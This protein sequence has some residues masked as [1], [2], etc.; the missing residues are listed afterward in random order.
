[1]GFEAIFQNFNLTFE[2]FFVDLLLSGDNAIIIALACRSLPK[3]QMQKAILFGVGAAIFLRVILTSIS[4]LILYIPVLRLVGGV[5]LVVIAVKLLIEEESEGS[6]DETIAHPT[7]F[8]H[9]VQTVVVADLIMS[10]DNVVALAAVAQGEMFF[11]FLGLLISVPFLMYGSM[12]VTKL[13][14]LYPVLI[15]A[16]GALLGWLAGHIAITDAIWDNW[17][18]A[19]SPGL[20]VIVPILTAMFVVLQSRIV[21]EKL[22]N[23]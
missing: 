12:F 7:S 9:A 22:R 13:L 6:D 15:Q 23:G 3:D 21:K 8:F 20:H 11:L 10:V 4:S 5:A 2:V 19:Q 14:R 17:I 16:G 1:M 18:S